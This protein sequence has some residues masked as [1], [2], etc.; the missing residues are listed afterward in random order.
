[1]SLLIPL[2]AKCIDDK[3]PLTVTRHT[4]ANIVC[5]EPKNIYSPETRL[6]SSNFRE[7]RASAISVL[8]ERRPGRGIARPAVD[9]RTR[10]RLTV[11][12]SSLVL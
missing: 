1:M 6:D 12:F 3:R 9:P 2:K 8:G 10:D 11:P 5:H 7:A 4:F